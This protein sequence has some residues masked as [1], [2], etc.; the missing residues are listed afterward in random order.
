M[1]FEHEYRSYEHIHQSA[2]IIQ[3]IAFS[4]IALFGTAL[5]IAAMQPTSYDAFFDLLWYLDADCNDNLITQS[6]S[7]NEE[8]EIILNYYYA[9]LNETRGFG[10][11]EIEWFFSRRHRN[12]WFH[13]IRAQFIDLLVLAELDSLR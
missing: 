4:N 6:N 7:A 8:V 12:T 9:Q 3:F 10:I 11:I 2:T 1:W 13:W 5:H